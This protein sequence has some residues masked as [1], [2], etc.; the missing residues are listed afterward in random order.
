MSFELAVPRLSRQIIFVEIPQADYPDLEAR[1][2]R[3]SEKQSH[4]YFRVAEHKIRLITRI[5]RRRLY[6]LYYSPGE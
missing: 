2:R 5:R 1:F 6:M 3:N 4:G